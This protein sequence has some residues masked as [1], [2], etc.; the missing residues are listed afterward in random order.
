MPSDGHDPPEGE[1]VTIVGWPPS[2][3]KIGVASGQPSTDS[4]STRATPEGTTGLSGCRPREDRPG[5]ERGAKVDHRTALD[6]LRT[7]TQGTRL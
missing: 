7:I 2:V 4:D 5:A 1:S 3:W 6:H